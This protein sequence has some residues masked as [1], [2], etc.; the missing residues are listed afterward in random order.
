NRQRA[1]IGTD[2]WR[3]DLGRR[4][5]ALYNDPASHTRFRPKISAAAIPTANVPSGGAPAPA[6]VSRSMPQASAAGG[7]LSATVLRWPPPGGLQAHIRGEPGLAGPRIV[8]PPMMPAGFPR[9]VSPKP[10]AHSTAGAP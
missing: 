10:S 1:G 5:S 3:H 7:P 8:A 2:T 9:A 6:A 4:P